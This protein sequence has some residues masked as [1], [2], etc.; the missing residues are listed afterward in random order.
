M[1]ARARGCAPCIAAVRAASH[2]LSAGTGHT[3]LIVL[4][5][6]AAA[7]AR[8]ITAFA[9]AVG[10]SPARYLTSDRD[11]TITSMLRS[12]MPRDAAVYDARGRIVSYPHADT[13][14]LTA[15]LQQARR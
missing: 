14:A 2:V 5:S 6:D 7:R 9:R 15:A 8:D 10:A 4:M 1:L 12:S 13:R 11:A 3:Q